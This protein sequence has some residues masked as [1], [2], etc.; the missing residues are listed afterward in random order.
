MLDEPRIDSLNAQCIM[1]ATYAL[2]ARD[3]WVEQSDAALQN[4]PLRARRPPAPRVAPLWICAAQMESSLARA[5]AQNE[6]ANQLDDNILHQLSRPL[7]SMASYA[8][9]VFSSKALSAPA[10][11]AASAVS[12]T[13]RKR[14]SVRVTPTNSAQFNS[15]KWSDSGLPLEKKSRV[16]FRMEDSDMLSDDASVASGN[17]AV[18]RSLSSVGGSMAGRS[19]GALKNVG[20]FFGSSFN[21]RAALKKEGQVR[22]TR[23]ELKEMSASVSRWGRCPPSRHLLPRLD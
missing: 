15:G 5:L 19:L 23:P 20:S 11:S 6:L 3:I 8:S 21:S 7:V 10:A 9:R 2:R 22:Q 17:S 14:N 12:L 18:A 1:L 13:R 16:S 4:P